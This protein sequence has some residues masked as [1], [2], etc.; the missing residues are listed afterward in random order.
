[1]QDIL[2]LGGTVLSMDPR[3]P[4]HTAVALRA[5]RVLAVGSAE[6]VEAVAAPGARRV[7]LAG[8]IVLPGFHDAHV[9]LTDYGFALAQLDL[10][11]APTME[12][13]LDLVATRAR[14]LPA[15]RPPEG[16]G[17]SLSRWGAPAAERGSLAPP[18]PAR[19]GI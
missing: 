5:G 13:A 7:D 16:A 4:R 18:A 17:L 1:M 10:Y 15:G 8:A 11:D 6:E 2:L 12:A 9:H 3:A 19:P 14:E